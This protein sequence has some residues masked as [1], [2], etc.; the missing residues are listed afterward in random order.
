[1]T[2]IKTTEQY[3]ALLTRIDE[4]LRTITDESPEHQMPHTL[5]IELD[6]LSEL[7]EE[8]EKEHYPLTPPTVAELLRYKMAELNMPQ[9]EVAKKLGVS[10]SRISEYMTGKAEP[11]L[12]IARVICKELHISPS[13]LLGIQ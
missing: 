10:P 3:K 11:T 12:K 1:M 9:N 2:R 13:L 4:I 7:V 6:M 5:S 8:Y